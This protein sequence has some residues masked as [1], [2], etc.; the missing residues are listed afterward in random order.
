[1]HQAVRFVGRYSIVP[2][3][4]A[5]AADYPAI[6]RGAAGKTADVVVASFSAAPGSMPSVPA[7]VFER[8]ADAV[9]YPFDGF[10]NP[11]ET[12]LPA[13]A[14]LAVVRVAAIDL[15][16]VPCGPAT[17]F[18]QPRGVAPSLFG[19]VPDPAG[20]GQTVRTGP[21]RVAVDPVVAIAVA[22]GLP[23]PA[24]VFVQPVDA[25]PY[26]CSNPPFPAWLDRDAHS[27]P[28]AVVAIVGVLLPAA[29]ASLPGSPATASAVLADQVIAENP[30]PNGMVRQALV[31]KSLIPHINNH[32]SNQLRAI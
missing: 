30:E 21:I 7:S 27:R 6:A 32:Q 11:A 1:M 26:P 8:L 23:A 28:A 31:L 15:A 12:D 3:D 20:T 24:I 25:G 4:K 10:P 14:G 29:F 22:P 2:A 16:F 13:R 18:V 5:L 19:S 9:P 17:A